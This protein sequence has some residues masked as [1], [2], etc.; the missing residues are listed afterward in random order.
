[1]WRDLKQWQFVGGGNYTGFI[2]LTLMAISCS[3]QTH[4]CFEKNDSNTYGSQT[5]C[6][7]IM[8]NYKLSQRNNLQ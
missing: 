2:P 7:L 8:K 6:G 5:I 4:N 3:N 1:M